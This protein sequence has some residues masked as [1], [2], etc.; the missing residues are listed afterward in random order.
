M[1]AEE[2]YK[3]GLELYYH[4]ATK[5]QGIELLKDATHEGS[6][7]AARALGLHYLELEAYTLANEYFE[8]GA[9]MGQGDCLYFLANAYNLG[10]GKEKDPV[11]AYQLL[12]EAIKQ[13]CKIEEEDYLVKLYKRDAEAVMY[14]G[15]F[16]KIKKWLKKMS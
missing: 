7:L 11:K 15:V 6:A 14:K 10:K 2:K 1:N 3:K 16:G 9:K 4:S 8:I 12:S 5:T 13:G